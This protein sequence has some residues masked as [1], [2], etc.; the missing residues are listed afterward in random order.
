[1]TSY[2]PVRVLSPTLPLFVALCAFGILAGALWVQ[3]QSNPPCPL[4]ILQRMAYLGMLAFALLAAGLAAAAQATASRLALLL[5]ALSGLAGLG[6]AGR[7]VWLVWHPGQ[8][9]GLD[10]LAAT[11]NNWSI[12]QWAPW[13]FRADGLCADVPSI[14]GVSLPLWSALGFILLTI[15]LLLSMRGSKRR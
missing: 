10:P 13:M 4:C 2:K 8:T 3:N 6:V 14:L 1:M 5:G 7:H 11:I 9:C 12:T 15:V